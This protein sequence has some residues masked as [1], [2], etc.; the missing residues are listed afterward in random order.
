MPTFVITGL[1]DRGQRLRQTERADSERELR[2]RF[3]AQGYMIETVRPQRAWAGQR[4]AKVA[5][6]K[7]LVFNQQFLT[8]I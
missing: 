1:N 7:F 3:S 2:E 6:D 5:T 4:R 8:L